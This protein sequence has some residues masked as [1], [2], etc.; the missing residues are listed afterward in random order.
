MDGSYSSARI[1]YPL[2][3]SIS[4]TSNLWTHQQNPFSFRFCWSTGKKWRR[5][6]VLDGE[7]K[8]S[9]WLKK[10][11][12]LKT[13]YLWKPFLGNLDIF[14]LSR[15]LS[16]HKINSIREVKV[17]HKLPE[18]CFLRQPR[19]GSMSQILFLFLVAGSLS[20]CRKHTS[21]KS[22]V[23]HQQVLENVDQSSSNH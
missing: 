15:I 16:F 20:G 8:K 21:R 19:T 22:S 17:V 12:P 4:I 18:V 10:Y 1:Q 6:E 13:S 2:T 3:T 5:E 14:Y 7:K 23:H 9:L 11:S